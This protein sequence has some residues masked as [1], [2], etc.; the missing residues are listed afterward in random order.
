MHYVQDDM[1]KNGVNVEMMADMG[2]WKK[3]TFVA[4]PPTVR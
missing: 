4:T 2:K 3:N 1:G